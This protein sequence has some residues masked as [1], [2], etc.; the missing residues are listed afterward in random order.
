ME[1]PTVRRLLGL[2]AALVGGFL[3]Y[4]A[5]SP[6]S[7]PAMAFW[8]LICGLGLFLLT[9]LALQRYYRPGTDEI[10]PDEVP[11]GEWKI[12]RFI[13]RGRD[14]SSL[15]LGIRLFLGWEWLEAGWHKFQDP[16]WLE[17]GEALR[18]YWERAAAIPKPPGKPPIAYPLYRSVIQYMLENGWESWFN[19]FIIFGEILIGIGLILGALTGIAVFFGLLMNFSFLY[20]GSAS[21]NP[22][23][24]ILGIFIIIGWRVAGWWGLD[25][26]LLPW[27]GTPWEPGAARRQ[28]K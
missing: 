16:R 17:T 22:T 13:R 23:F 10:S 7:D 12:G 28:K 19:T 14:A 15:F 3:L 5:A 26:I 2:I 1:N 6:T 20:A 25:R 24:I 9:L 8:S 27:L 21:S 4:L 18:A 11:V